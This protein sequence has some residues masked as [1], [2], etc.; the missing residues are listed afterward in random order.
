MSVVPQTGIV[1]KYCEL[2]SENIEYGASAFWQVWLQREFVQNDYERETYAVTS[3]MSPDG[4][5]RRVDH[6]V[7]RYEPNHHN[8]S[9]MVWNECK[10]PKGS[11]RAAEDQAL[12]AAIRC[13]D[14]EK[15]IYIYTL[16]TVGTT[17]RVWE[18]TRRDRKP[19]PFTPETTTGTP[20]TP[21]GFVDVDSGLGYSL[22]DAIQ[23]M[24]EKV[25]LGEAPIVPSQPHLL[26]QMVRVLRRRRRPE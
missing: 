17:F 4:S 22:R 13:I 9:S 23:Y 6:V 2:V 19:R 26:Q 12:D 3:E 7:K 14:R 5:L 10:R 11:A 16:T 15:L 20:F 1:R 25:P 8:L 18:V 21:S 24:K